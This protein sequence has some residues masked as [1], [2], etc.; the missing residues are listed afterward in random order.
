MKGFVLRMWIAM[1]IVFG[2]FLA[3][4][5]PAEAGVVRFVGRCTAVTA[6]CTYKALRAVGRV[7]VC[8]CRR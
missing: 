7:V 5:A 3:M 1:A 6:K 8:T 4:P 2:S